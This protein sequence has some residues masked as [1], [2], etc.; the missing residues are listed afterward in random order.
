MLGKTYSLPYHLLRDKHT[1]FFRVLN[2]IGLILIVFLRCRLS[3]I[4]T[5][6]RGRTKKGSGER[7]GSCGK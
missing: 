2:C 3:V 6:E 4:F 1:R 7:K 5:E